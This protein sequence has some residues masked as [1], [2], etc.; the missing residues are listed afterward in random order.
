MREPSQAARIAALGEGQRLSDADKAPKRSEQKTRN[1]DASILADVP[2]VYGPKHNVL[3]TDRDVRIAFGT[4]YGRYGDTDEVEYY[5]PRFG[6]A[7]YM[8]WESARELHTQL[9]SVLA[10]YEEWLKGRGEGEAP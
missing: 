4:S 10:D 6:V 2:E 5:D 7:V 1:Y 9:A 3:F 8:P